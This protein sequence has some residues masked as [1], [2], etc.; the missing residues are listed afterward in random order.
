LSQLYAAELRYSIYC[1]CDGQEHGVGSNVRIAVTSDLHYDP[2]GYLLVASPWPAR[3]RCCSNSFC[4]RMILCRLFEPLFPESASIP[5]RPVFHIEKP[6][7]IDAG[8]VG[9][10]AG[11]FP[12]P[13]IDYQTSTDGIKFNVEQCAEES[14][15]F[16]DTGEEPVLPGMSRLVLP[17]LKPTR[18]ILVC[19]SH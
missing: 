3:F 16:D 4:K 18:I 5:P 1:I 12:V 15:L 11:P 14:F 2:Y 17:D 19:P 7:R 9:S 8:Y 10:S 6:G 13:C